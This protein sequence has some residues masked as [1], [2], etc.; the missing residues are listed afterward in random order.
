MGKSGM[1]R[2]T[3]N[4][5]IAGVCGGLADYYGISSKRIRWAFF[6]FGL[7]GAGEILYIILWILLPKST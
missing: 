4:K 2:S 3:R 1:T 6:F 5:M 7:L